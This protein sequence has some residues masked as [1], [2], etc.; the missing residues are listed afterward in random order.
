MNSLDKIPKV[1]QVESQE[2]K[3]DNIQRKG[4]RNEGYAG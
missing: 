3:E 2:S 1:H 4:Q